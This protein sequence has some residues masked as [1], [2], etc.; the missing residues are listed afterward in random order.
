MVEALGGALFFAV[1]AIVAGVIRRRTRLGTT[2]AVALGLLVA[3]GLGAAAV[4][5]TSA[6]DSRRHAAAK[7]ANDKRVCEARKELGIPADQAGLAP[8]RCD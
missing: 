5:T 1:A 6:I 7:A 4:A 3:V 8:V 2:A